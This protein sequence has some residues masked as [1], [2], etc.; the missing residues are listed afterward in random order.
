MIHTSTEQLL[1]DIDRFKMLD[2]ERKSGI[3][4]STYQ[5]TNSTYSVMEELLAR[6]KGEIFPRSFY[7]QSWQWGEPF[8]DDISKFLMDIS[9]QGYFIDNIVLSKFVSDNTAY[10]TFIVGKDETCET[11]ITADVIQSIIYMAELQLQ[12]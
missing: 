3:L 5:P 12:W 6:R 9:I 7:S 11:N 10:I 8:E 1:L 2:G 4:F